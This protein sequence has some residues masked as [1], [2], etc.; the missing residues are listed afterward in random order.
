L[1]DIRYS[2]GGSEKRILS[3]GDAVMLST[4]IYLQDAYGVAI[5]TFHTFD[6]AKKKFVPLLGYHEWCEKLTGEKDAL[7]RR[8][9]AMK[10]E[11][12]LH[13]MPR[14]AGT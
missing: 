7:A 12:P 5:D 4:A 2:K 6:N 13:P 8:V 10:R 3:T 9:C 1:K 14:L 11:K